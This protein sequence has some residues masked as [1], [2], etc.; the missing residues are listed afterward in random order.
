[1]ELGG[2]GKWRENENSGHRLVLDFFVSANHQ[3]AVLDS[4]GGNQAVSDF[5]DDAG[6]AS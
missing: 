1:L 4:L 5:F 3:F 2:F 6:L